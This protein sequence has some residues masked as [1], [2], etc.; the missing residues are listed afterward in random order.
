MIYSHLNKYFLY[1]Y[2]VL[3]YI[4]FRMQNFVAF[5]SVCELFFNCFLPPARSLRQKRKSLEK[6]SLLLFSLSLPHFTACT[7][8]LKWKMFSKETLFYK[9]WRGKKEREI[10]FT[11]AKIWINLLGYQYVWNATIYIWYL[12]IYLFWL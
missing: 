10:D 5:P 1:R 9:F 4:V 2:T 6:G 3:S 8:R 12:L 11:L 7:S